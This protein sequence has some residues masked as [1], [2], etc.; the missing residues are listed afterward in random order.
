MLGERVAEEGLPSP[1]ADEVGIVILKPLLSSPLESVVVELER[2]N[3]DVGW[4]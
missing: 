3:E 2:D 4:P 1:R